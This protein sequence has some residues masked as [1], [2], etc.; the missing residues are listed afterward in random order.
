[1]AQQHCLP[2]LQ[3]LEIQQ[4]SERLWQMGRLRRISV[5]PVGF[6]AKSEPLEQTMI[7]FRDA[8]Q[9]LLSDLTGTVLLVMH[10]SL[11]SAQ[12]PSITGWNPIYRATSWAMPSSS[13]T[14]GILQETRKWH[15]EVTPAFLLQWHS[16][17]PTTQ[18]TVS[19]VA[20]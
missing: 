11:Q 18:A 9:Q 14:K 2:A 5:R 1:M 3:T 17:S 7:S 10:G 6:E 12:G 15:Q 4:G 19:G 16:S 8:V 13:P 20:L